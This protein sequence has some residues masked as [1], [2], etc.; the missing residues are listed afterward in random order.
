M[1][2][3]LRRLILSSIHCRGKTVSPIKQ[4]RIRIVT[5]LALSKADGGTEGYMGHCVFSSS[6]QLRSVSHC[7]PV[8]TL[9]M[10]ITLVALIPKREHKISRVHFQN[11]SGQF[12]V[13]LSESEPRKIMGRPENSSQRNLFMICKTRHGT[14]G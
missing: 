2:S 14:N 5:L 1:P 4:N 8:P 6:Y 11:S 13:M 7:S 9:T 12:K 10:C 3:D